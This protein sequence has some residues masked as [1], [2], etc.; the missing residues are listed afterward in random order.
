MA[1]IVRLVSCRPSPE[2]A[3][4]MP[5]A[6]LSYTRD[7]LLLLPTSYTPAPQLTA[8]S[9][10]GGRPRETDAEEGLN[11]AEYDGEELTDHHCPPCSSV[12]S[13]EEQG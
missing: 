4:A 11:G 1:F 10:P 7:Q 12:T 6:L 8:G 3:G 2:G 5:T 13:A 9:T